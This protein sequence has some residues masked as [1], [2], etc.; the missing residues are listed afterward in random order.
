[1]GWK[2]G[3]L[4]AQKWELGWDRPLRDWQQALGIEPVSEAL[5]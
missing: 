5:P 2:A 3:N 1:M 4:L